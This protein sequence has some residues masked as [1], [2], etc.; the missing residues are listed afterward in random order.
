MIAYPSVAG[1]L[2]RLGMRTLSWKSL[3]VLFLLCVPVRA[4]VPGGLTLHQLAKNAGY[5]FSGT[6]TAV[7]RVRAAR[8]DEVETIRVTFRV[9]EGVRG[10]RS[11]QSLTIRE[12]AGLWT[13]GERYRVGEHVVLMLYRPSRAGLTSP[14]GGSLGRFALD[15]DG[16]LVPPA[17][18][19]EALANDP[20]AGPW[21]QGQSRPRGR[22]FARLLR[23]VAKE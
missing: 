22:D 12:W 16:A 13:A 7:E 17:Q 6:V 19:I 11:R 20:V 1:L 2:L 14:V 18:Q 8:P 23:R 3:A 10:V 21:L 4:Q 15:H 5:I 9:D